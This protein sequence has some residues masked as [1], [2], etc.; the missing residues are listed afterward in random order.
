MKTIIP[1]ASGKGGVGKTLLTANLAL[2]LA[3]L[4]HTTIAVDLDLGNS[5]LH[6]FLGLPNNYPG[7]G[8]FLK[9][10]SE[11]LKPFKIDTDIPYLS[12]IAGDGR[13]PLMADI[14][15]HQK[16]KI[17]QEIKKLEADYIL[18]DLGAGSHNNILDLFGIANR[19]IIV[20]TPENPSVISMLV[21]M[22]NYLLRLIDRLARVDL[23]IIPVLQEIFKQPTDGPQRT[24]QVYRD[25]IAKI[26]PE[27]AS[28]ID[29][30]CRLTRPRFIYNM[31][32]NPSELDILPR[33]DN[34]L[35]KVFSIKG[36]HLGF[37]FYDPGVRNSINAGVPLLL[38]SPNG[39]TARSIKQIASRMIKAWDVDIIDS[40][41]RLK[42]HTIKVY[43]KMTIKKNLYSA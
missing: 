3:A 41:R 22:K 13:M 27:V 4:E 8:D 1:V 18:L 5:N 29:N 39:R 12:Y 28:K 40:S 38:N 25:K 43:D 15:Y 2:T 37:I 16:R 14:T 10:Q 23:D 20:T 21:F 17:L 24:L 32:E 36:D 30:I 7:I 31:G 9:S 19:G 34:T 26:N 35:K 11:S 6:S 42:E 33:I